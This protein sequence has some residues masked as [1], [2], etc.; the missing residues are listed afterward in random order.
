MQI[1]ETPFSGENDFREMETLAREFRSDNLHVTD[2][3]YRI[4]SWAINDPENIGLWK[5][6]SGSLAAWAIL[7]GPF[8]SV[9]IACQPE[10]EA[11][12]IPNI[13]NWV[14]ER[15][16]EHPDRVPRG[17][18]SGGRCWFIDAFSDQKER[19][20]ALESAGYACQAN[21]GDYSLSEVLMQRQ[22]SIPV[23]EYRIP[24][25]F[26]IRP[27]AGESE[28]EAYVDLHQKTFDTKNMTVD[29][30]LRTLHHPDYRP[31]LDLVVVSPDQR[32][33]A[34]CIG[35]LDDHGPEKTGQIEPLGCHPDFRQFALGRL[36]LAEGL[37]RLQN[38]GAKK[39]FVET[40]S[41]RNTAFQLYESLGFQVV[42]DVLVYRKDY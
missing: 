29:W 17:T 41:W 20:R 28:V 40:D 24:E 10:L 35:W 15:S 25:G 18:P 42:R 27:M 7:Q 34:F 39:M 33:A 23:K 13:L 14:D 38:L 11:S 8:C 32:L 26:V 16:R 22:A 31:E 19:V 5:D 3:P 30:R 4:S 9:D 2:L 6:A 21:V 12:L 37:R 1:L 36:A